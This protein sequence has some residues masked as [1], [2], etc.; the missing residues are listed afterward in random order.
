ML[1]E[2]SRIFFSPSERIKQILIDA[3]KEVVL[4]INT[5]KTITGMDPYKDTVQQREMYHK[6]CLM[7]IQMDRNM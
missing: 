6:N 3:S 2:V 7:M 5:E 1:T 4:E